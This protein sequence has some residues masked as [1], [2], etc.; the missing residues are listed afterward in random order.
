M[1]WD[2]DGIPPTHSYSLF[3]QA[4]GCLVQGGN[5]V[6]NTKVFACRQA[7]DTITLQNASAQVSGGGKYGRWAFLPVTD[8]ELI[9]RRPTEQLLAGEVNGV[10]I[11][12]GASSKNRKVS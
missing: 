7:K 2:Y 9:Q 4:A 6:N 8:G 3:A 11:L 5:A 1:Q 10:R 12:S